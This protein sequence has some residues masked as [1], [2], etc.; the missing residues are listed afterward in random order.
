MPRW[1]RISLRIFISIIVIII[2]LWVALVIYIQANKK[3]VLAYITEQLSDQMQGELII[4]DMQPSLWRSFPDVSVALTHVSVHDSLYAR[5]HHS[6]LELDALYV[7]LNSLQLL[8]KK[9]EIKKITASHGKIDLFVD[10]L[11]YSNASVFSKKDTT[12]VKKKTKF[13][14]NNFGMEHILFQYEDKRKNKTF[15]LNFNEFNGWAFFTDSAW[16]VAANV[17]ISVGGL[18][19]NKERGAFLKNSRLKTQLNFK[20]QPATK[21]MSFV[22]QDLNINKWVLKWTADFSFKDA[23]P[24]FNMTFRATTVPFDTVKSWLSDFIYKKL[25]SLHFTQPVVMNV[26]LVGHFKYRDTPDVRVLLQARDNELVTPIASF[27]HCSF[28]AEYF[29]VFKPGMGHSDANTFVALRKLTAEWKKIPFSAD[30]IR[31]NNLIYAALEFQLHSQFPLSSLYDAAQG[32]PFLFK[33]GIADINLHYKGGVKT[34]D[35]LYPVVQG[36]ISVKDGV[37]T[38][39]P[40]GLEFSS[41]NASLLLQGDDLFFTDLSFHSPHSNLKMKGY[42]LHFFRFYFT[43]PEK[44]DVNWQVLCKDLDLGDFIAFV[45]KRKFKEAK[46]RGNYRGTERIINQLDK[47]LDQSVVHLQVGL[48]RVHYHRFV[49]NNFVASA[50]LS[51]SAI[52]LSDVRL[53]HAG[54]TIDVSGVIKQDERN[55]P[56]SLK[57]KITD[58]SV[59]TLFYAFNNFGQSAIDSTNIRGRLNADCNVVGN[60]SEGG[61]I[62]PGSLNGT[63]KFMLEDGA[64]VHFEPLEKMGKIIFRNRDMSNIIFKNISNELQVRGNKIIIPPMNIVS[65]ALYL[66]V[67][68]VYAKPKGTDILIEVPLRNP[69]KDGFD[70]TGNF[71]PRQSKKKGLIL[72]LR[73]QDGD[74]GKVKINWDP[75]MKG[76]KATD[77]MSRN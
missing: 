19:F 23:T 48:D 38:Y 25:D 73:A 66:N 5:H 27:Q 20:Y 29:N 11:G 72:Y 42:A 24:L 60:M 57:A 6:L 34:T 21:H 40:R 9:I 54:G 50:A 17:D 1:L 64:L 28:D 56:F 58:V 71:K 76:V 7:K 26:N 49:A 43:A 36:T 51:Q 39:L 63:V 15:Q 44:V 37:V 47:V 62:I 53:K 10:S 69:K 77:S 30:S 2:G 22:A 46:P 8:R 45:G 18:N 67:Q 59:H 55:N 68:G 52:E 33:S 4:K 14:C 13:S 65:S 12:T 75:L 70:T 35:T 31:V 61:K 74:D 16:S 32:I 3:Q 41:M